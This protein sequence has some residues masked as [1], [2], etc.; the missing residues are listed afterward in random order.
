M[1][2]STLDPEAAT[3]Q[4]DRIE[5]RLATI[6][7][8]LEA[9]RRERDRWRDLTH[10]LMPVAQ[11]AMTVA[12]A[13]LEE[14]SQDVTVEDLVRFGRTAARSLPRLEALL[15]QLDSMGELVHEATSLTGAGVASVSGVLATA[16]DKGYFTFARGAAAIVDE[17]VES[18]GED[19]LR[20][21][22]ANVVLILNTVKQMTQPEV[23][24]FLSRTVDDVQIVDDGPPPS[25]LALLRRLRDPQVR[26]GLGRAL[27][28]LRDL[29]SVPAR[30]TPRPTTE[31]E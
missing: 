6:M 14:L 30:T 23:M 19:D 10:D 24:S 21:L 13:E 26:R 11:G 1:S 31:K 17:I 27:T 3:G 25:T 7:D 4:L 9:T 8:E 15:A 22:G 20:A 2:T 5:A 16:E 12:S 18:F 29:G 28:V